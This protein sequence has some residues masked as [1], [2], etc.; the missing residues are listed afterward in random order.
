MQPTK[1]HIIQTWLH[2]MSYSEPFCKSQKNKLY[3]ARMYLCST[4]TTILPRSLAVLKGGS[5]IMMCVCIKSLWQPKV[6]Y[7]FWKQIVG[8]IIKKF[9]TFC[10]SQNIITICTSI[11]HW[12]VSWASWITSTFFK[13]HFNI[14]SHPNLGLQ[15]GLFPTKFRTI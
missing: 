2:Q 6:L 10:D 13:L 4:P 8:P 11:Y 15:S 3:D 7:L 12:T 1:W 5:L 9:V 14:I